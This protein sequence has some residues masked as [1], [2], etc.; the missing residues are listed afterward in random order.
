MVLPV[1]TALEIPFNFTR[2]FFFDFV[3]H[4]FKSS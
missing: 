2:L 3:L 1:G 4:S